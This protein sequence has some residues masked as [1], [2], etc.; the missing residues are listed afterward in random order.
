MNEI[1]FTLKDVIY[2]CTLLI[3]V[4]GVYYSLKIDMKIVK[5]DIEE[6]Q[7]CHKDQS[8]ENKKLSTKLD[9]LLNQIIQ[10]NKLL[11]EHIAYHK[12]VEDATK[13]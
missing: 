6:I 7:K 12:G 2:I 10:S 3:S 11:G 4:V 9:D 5:K 1:T 8:E 13:N